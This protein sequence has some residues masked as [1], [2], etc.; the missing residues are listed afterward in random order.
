MA[1]QFVRHGVAH[2]KLLNLAA[3]SH[4]KTVYEANV[5]WDFVMG[6][7]V[8]AEC[9]DAFLVADLPI[10]EPDPS[11]DLFAVFWIGDAKDL[12]VLHLRMSIEKFFDLAGVDVLSSPDH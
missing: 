5:A 12:D 6:D 3:D 1:T 2:H 11:A 8:T 9:P 7:G 4:R 10:S